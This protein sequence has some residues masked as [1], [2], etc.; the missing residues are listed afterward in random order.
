MYDIR[1]QA[2]IEMSKYTDYIQ[3]YV[4]KFKVPVKSITLDRTEYYKLCRIIIELN[5]FNCL[6]YGIEVLDYST[7]HIQIYTWCGV[8]TVLP[9]Q[10]ID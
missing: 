7:M 10:T 2:Q 3:Q 4:S 8:V 6:L 1:S 9:Q 5:T